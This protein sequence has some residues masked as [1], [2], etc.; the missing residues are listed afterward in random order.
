MLTQAKAPIP[1]PKKIHFI[2]LGGAIP[3]KYLQ[4]IIGLVRVAKNSGFE[5][6]LW[7]DDEKNYRKTAEE[8]KKG[9]GA[10]LE[11]TNETLDKMLGIKVR[12]IDELKNR[13]EGENADP[14]YKGTDVN[15][16]LPPGENLPKSFWQY[17]NLERIG[18]KNLSAAS[19]LLRFE[20]LRQEGGYYV[21]TDTEFPT[22]NPPMIPDFLYTESQEPIDEKMMRQY[23]DYLKKNS[24]F[25][26]DSKK[27]LL[28]NKLLE[29]CPMFGI[30][31]NI[32]PKFGMSSNKVVVS[33][34]GGNSDLIGAIP[35]HEVISNA[36]V[37]ALRKYKEL[38]K[39]FP[40]SQK[41]YLG[42]YARRAATAMDIKRYPYYE[43][44]SI[45][46][47]RRNKTIDIGP[48]SL[49]QAIEKFWDKQDD[50]SLN[51]YKSLQIQ[52]DSLETKTVIFG[53]EAISKFDNTWLKFKKKDLRGYDLEDIP[54]KLLTKPKK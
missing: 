25:T 4:S 23:I 49:I 42:F 48:A 19:D 53:V 32:E 14:L 20:I 27:K 52:E 22:I 31:A 51:A 12:N 34:W 33:D 8:F 28:S 9:L 6:N 3:F 54:E 1:I 37:I 17:V 47:F 15:F 2:W 5:V 26:K 13:M 35:S 7:V 10:G 18:S 43:A 24:E 46:N 38:E 39:L 41:E 11:A 45:L 29:E 30:K 16:P 50:H 44:D 40:D 36:I 21:D